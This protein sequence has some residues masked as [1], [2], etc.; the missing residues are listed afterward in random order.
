MRWEEEKRTMVTFVWAGPV[1]MGLGK[2]VSRTKTSM[3]H[4]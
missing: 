3:W 1:K 4:L 2:V